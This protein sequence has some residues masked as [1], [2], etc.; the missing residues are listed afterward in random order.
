MARFF[1]DWFS[2]FYYRFG[3][4][5]LVLSF[6]AGLLFGLLFYNAGNTGSSLMQGICCYSLSIV[7]LLPILIL[8]LFLSVIAVCL[9]QPWIL[10]FICFGKS[11]LFSFVS[12]HIFNIFGS[13]GWIIRL[14]VIF[15]EL[16]VLP[17][18][19][20]FWNR[21]I[22]GIRRCDIVEVFCVFSGIV[23]I[24]SIDCC[25]ISPFLRSVLLF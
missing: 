4:L 21:H 3:K 16:F 2:G 1:I 12:L 13:A 18:H 17:I 25:Y 24:G 10:L 19:Y 5:F 23:L 22:S 14:L 9:S 15:S 20:W 11:F 8:P 7:L 6:V